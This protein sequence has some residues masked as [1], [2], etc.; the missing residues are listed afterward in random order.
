[1]ND[2]HVPEEL[3]MEQ[4]ERILRDVSLGVPPPDDESEAARRWRERMEGQVDKHREA[5]MANDIPFN[6]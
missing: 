6:G 4:R 3:T 1:M 5:G 2:D